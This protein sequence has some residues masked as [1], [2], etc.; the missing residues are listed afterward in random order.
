MTAAALPSSMPLGRPAQGSRV[1]FPFVLF[2]ACF[3]ELRFAAAPGYPLVHPC[4]NGRI[5]GRW[6]GAWGFARRNRLYLSFV[7][8]PRQGGIRTTWSTLWTDRCVAPKV[9]VLEVPVSVQSDERYVQSYPPRQV[10]HLAPSTSGVRPRS[11]EPDPLTPT[12]RGCRPD[13][14]AEALPSSGALD[15]LNA[16]PSGREDAP[17]PRT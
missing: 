13:G 1:P 17:W 6:K 12:R 14:A 3:R 9:S 2:L 11:P 5:G 15:A 7:N 10:P 8:A 4:E 16:L